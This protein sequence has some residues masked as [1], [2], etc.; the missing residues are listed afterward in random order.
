MLPRLVAVL[1]R[2]VA[3]V[4][5]C[6]LASAAVTFAAGNEATP[7]A[8]P[9]TTTA[10]EPAVLVVPDVRQQA[11]VFAKGT[12]EDAGFAWK[13]E[14]GAAGYAAN[15]V[16]AQSPAPGT[17]VVDT[18]APLLTLRLASNPQYAAEGEPEDASPYAG[19]PL[20]LADLPSPAPAPAAVT[21]AAP[22][23]AKAAQPAQPAK[24]TKPA[25]PS[26]TSKPAKTAARTRTATR[27]VAAAPSARPAA[28]TAPGAPAEPLDEIALPARA[29]RL[30][31]YVAAHPK[32]TN[33]AARHWLYQHTWIVTGARFGW[34]HGAEALRTLIAVDRRVEAQWG[35][36][37][38]SRRVAQR[39]LAEVEAKS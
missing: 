33:A 36:G 28:F 21:T 16:V 32:L 30:A 12:L 14:G 37:A 29:K 13:L 27:A 24:P 17:R 25:K 6:V 22:P 18:G 1:P 15:V 38:K 2:F 34:W 26:T 7:P 10:A 35:L 23:A 5:V 9:A 11:Y 20:E 4:V 3:I 19:T 39:A 8:V 31:S